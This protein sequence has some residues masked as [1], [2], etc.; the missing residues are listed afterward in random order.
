[1]ADVVPATNAALP[2]WDIIGAPFSGRSCGS[3]TACCTQVPV[4]LEDGAIKPANIR[5]RHLRASKRCSVYAARP[6]DCRAWSCRWL[7]DRDA[8]GLRRPDRGGYIV[9]PMLDTIL[10]NSEPVSTLQVWVDPR[11][12]DAHRSPELRLY[13]AD[14]ADR[15]GV[16]AIV[17]WASDEGMVLFAP[18]LIGNAGWVERRSDPVTEQLLEAKL[19][20]A[21][22]GRRRFNH[23]D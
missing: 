22:P 5:C 16:P 18:G 3:C 2:A 11:R 10:L 14:V 19:A 17:R 8:E 15:L 20:Q 1:M 23:V 7:F 13:L 4:R 9:D 6:L 12:R 21:E